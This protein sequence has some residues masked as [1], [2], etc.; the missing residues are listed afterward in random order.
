MT[1]RKK[2]PQAL[3][4]THVKGRDGE[5]FVV[6]VWRDEETEPGYLWVRALVFN[7]EHWRPQLLLVAVKALSDAREIE[8]V[9]YDDTD[10]CALKKLAERVDTDIKRLRRDRSRS[11]V[12]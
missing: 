8:L 6:Y 1:R 2:K 5:G 4:A 3:R 11:H 10:E 9:I 7:G 12:L